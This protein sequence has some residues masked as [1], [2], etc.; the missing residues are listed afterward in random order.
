MTRCLRTVNAQR[1]VTELHL[2]AGVPC[3]HTHREEAAYTSSLW[4]R[5]ALVSNGIDTTVWGLC[6]DDVYAASS[7][8]NLNRQAT[9]EEERFGGCSSNDSRLSVSNGFLKATL[10]ELLCQLSPV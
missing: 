9:G 7:R 10:C 3:S 1:R 4:G 8:R 2:V 6:G 5:E